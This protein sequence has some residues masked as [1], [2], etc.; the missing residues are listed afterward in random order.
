MKQNQLYYIRD[1]INY[2]DA[3]EIYLN[4]NTLCNVDYIICATGYLKNYLPFQIVVNGQEI[5]YD[6]INYLQILNLNIPACGFI[7][8]APSYNW[9]INS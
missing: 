6:N 1:T 3:R 8:M 4:N 2:L 9:L 5:I 7:G